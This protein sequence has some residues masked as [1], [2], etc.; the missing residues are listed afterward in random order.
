MPLAG[1]T[2]PLLL[3]GSSP[4]ASPL[5]LVRAGPSPW[6]GPQVGAALGGTRR[7][8]MSGWD[9]AFEGGGRSN[10]LPPLAPSG[11]DASTRAHRLWAPS[12][13]PRRVEVLPPLGASTSG[14]VPSMAGA[15]E[16][17]PASHREVAYQTLPHQQMF[18][19]RG[20]A[21]ILRS[22]AAGKKRSA[23]PADEAQWGGHPPKAGGHPNGVGRPPEGGPTGD[24]G[25]H[26]APLRGGPSGRPP[27]GAA[28]AKEKQ[29]SLVVDSTPRGGVATPTRS[30]FD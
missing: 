12:E 13:A 24:G 28:K 5:P 4:L 19:S 15:P 3:A 7:A 25:W 1:R 23:P 2:A 27:Q 30:T 20:F 29:A 21:D 11:A 14:R 9:K 18:F 26:M 22:S 16:G 17:A 8:K 10:T 6:E